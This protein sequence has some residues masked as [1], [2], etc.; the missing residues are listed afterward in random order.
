VTKKWTLCAYLLLLAAWV[1][2]ALE[3]LFWGGIAFLLLGIWGVADN[4]NKTH[5][6]IYVV[7]TAVFFAFILLQLV[8]FY[9]RGILPVDWICLPLVGLIV[10]EI[11]HKTKD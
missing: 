8:W 7:L 6:I 1:L 9:P 11:F 2:F 10:L 3:Q 4:W 5:D